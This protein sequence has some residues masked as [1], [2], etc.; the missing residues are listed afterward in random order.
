MADQN[1][2]ELEVLIVAQDASLRELWELRQDLYALLENG[3]LQEGVRLE[4]VPDSRTLDP[5]VIGAI[6]VVLL[7][8]VADKLG[9]LIINWLN[10]HNDCTVTIKVP[11]EEGQFAEI[12]YH[13][14]VPED[15]LR[16]AI[17]SAKTL[18]LTGKQ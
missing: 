17:M 2:V 8:I 6:G 13:H 18:S 11:I 3:L 4:Q 12:T 10:T 16:A 7:P 1:P 9:D 14:G 5:A 15:K